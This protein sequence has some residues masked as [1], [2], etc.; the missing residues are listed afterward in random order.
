LNPLKTIRQIGSLEQVC[1]AAGEGL[2]PAGPPVFNT[3]IHLPPNFSAFESVRQAVDLAAAQNVGVLGAGNYYDFTVYQEF[4]S[5]AEAKGIF[6][7]FSTEIIALDEDLCGKGIRVND[8]GNPGKIY[9]CGK[10]ISRFADPSPQ[11][12]QLLNTIRRN[13]ALRM[14][15]MIEKM[16][17]CFRRVGLEMN[18]DDTVVIERIVRRHQ[19]R[20][21]TVT[22]QER[23]AAQAF[24]EVFFEKVPA[25]RRAAKLTELFGTD[26]KSRPEDAVGIQNE[27]RSYLMKA[28]KSC[29]VEETFLSPAQA[30][31]LIGQLGGIACYPVLAD[32]ASPICEYEAPAERLIEWLRQKQYTMVEF[33]P[34]RNT[35]QTLTEYVRAIRAAGILVTAG[36]EHNTLD[37]LPLEPACR[38][39]VSIPEDLKDLFWEGTCVLAAHQFL[40]AHDQCGFVD[41]A[42]RPNP[43]YKDAQSRMEAFRNIGRAVIEMYFQKHRNQG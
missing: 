38:Q 2:A 23:H 11:G 32:G 25:R 22:L 26:P 28:G 16:C 33:I 1:A 13:D 24:Q 18:L 17:D 40:S 8:P 36:T 9:L 7:L 41:S 6:P 30:E 34:L 3:H 15:Q 43:E 20:R 21:E 10:G 5:A 42:G 31:Q 37:L 12:L 27:I 4:A 19:C 39:G 29:F 35:P 14:R